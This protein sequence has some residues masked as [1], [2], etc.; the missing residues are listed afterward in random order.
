MS[1]SGGQS[2]ISIKRRALAQEL[3]AAALSDG[4]LA[5]LCFLALYRLKPSRS[6]LVFDEP[7]LHL[8]PRV[9]SR[10][11]DFFV[12]MSTMHPV[13]LTTH[14]D[15]LLDFLPDPA[16]QTT[17]A[18]LD[19]HDHTVFDHPDAEALAAWLK[20]YRGL[21]AVRADGNEDSV[22]IEAV[23]KTA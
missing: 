1:P 7:E 21:G 12:S 11:T 2:A 13:L 4:S 10:V 20:D 5:F 8:H 14:S 22:F 9:L 17:R 6:L 23:G 3:P 19:E 16:Q 15:R 18:M